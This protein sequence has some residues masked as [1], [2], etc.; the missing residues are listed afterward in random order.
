[1]PF[2]GVVVAMP[3]LSSTALTSTPTSQAEY[4]RALGATLGQGYLFGAPAAGPVDA[5]VT[6]R[7]LP[8][9]SAGLP[10]AGRTATVAAGPQRHS[11]ADRDPG[12]G[13][14]AL[15]DDESA[16]IGAGRQRW[17]VRVR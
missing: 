11:R 9:R 6:T 8:I 13:F 5:E 2:D 4:A 17:A 10:H 7:A 14:R 12:A 1:M 15:V 16:L 3:G